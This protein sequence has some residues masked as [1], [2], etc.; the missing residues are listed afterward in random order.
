MRI[1][2]VSNNLHI[3]GVQKALVSL[4]WNIHK[5]HD[6]TLLLFHPDGKL[7]KELPPDTKLISPRSGFRFL[8]TTKHD[9]KGLEYLR[10]SFYAAITRLF[11]RKAALRLMSAGQDTLGEYDVAVSYLHNGADNAFYGGCTEFVLSHVK[12]K[13]KIA[14]LHCDWGRSGANTAYNAELYSRFDGIAACSRGCAE[15]FVSLNPE[16]GDRVH[17][18]YNCH[19]YEDIR[20]RAAEAEVELPSDRLNIVTVARLGPEKGVTRALEAIAALG[21]VRRRIHYYIIGDGV[22]KPQV[23]ELMRRY[24]LE[25]T[26]TLLGEMENPYGYIGAADLLLIPS[27]SEAAPLV[28]GE[29]TALGTPVLSTKTSSAEEMILTP[30][31]GWV[32]ENSAEGIRS[33]LELLI[34]SP[35]LL[36][37]KRQTLAKMTF[38]NASAAEQFDRLIRN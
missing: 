37:K 5:E 20:S 26:V 18:V 22:E 21:A 38:D 34:I 12:A 24:S 33:E 19:R 11:G 7:L 16:L 23:L 36:T 9:V 13:R 8:G 15:A 31:L 35:E 4:L 14:F 10:R 27:R 3:G 28:I 6:V 30:G 1:L 29:A 25:S 2:I 17:V 32:C